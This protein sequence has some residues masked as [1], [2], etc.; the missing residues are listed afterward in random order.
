MPETQADLITAGKG[1]L[2]Q[3]KCVPKSQEAGPA[4]EEVATVRTLLQ[5]AFEMQQ[6][7]NSYWHDQ[8]MGG[9]QS[10]SFQQVTSDSWGPS[11]RVL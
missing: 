3:H 11:H 4:P 7:E 9:Y 5:R 1:C 2:C 10:R 6:H 8:I